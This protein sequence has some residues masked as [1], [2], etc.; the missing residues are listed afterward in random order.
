ML[1]VNGGNLKKIIILILLSVT[2]L[3]SQEKEEKKME[4]KNNFLSLST[5]GI[6]GSGLSYK[7]R[8]DNGLALKGTFFIF[9]ASETFSNQGDEQDL[10]L[11]F[12]TEIQYDINITSKER[13]YLLFGF[14][15]RETKIEEDITTFPPDPDE[16]DLNTE[17]FNLFSAGPG[18]GIEFKVDG[19][20]FFNG[21]AGFIYFSQEREVIEGTNDRN[22]TKETGFTFGAGVG[23]S[24]NF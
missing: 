2:P 4:M 10:W 3:L 15:Y 23:I 9:S 12:G 24:Y 18:V 19:D 17:N 8:F 16:V 1:Y 14:K 21:E 20:I 5:S 11:N 13:L 7:Y 6:S 22:I